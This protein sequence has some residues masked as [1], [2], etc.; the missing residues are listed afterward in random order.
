MR[1]AGQS[2]HTLEIAPYTY[3][4]TTCDAFKGRSAFVRLS[5]VLGAAFST[6]TTDR[7][8]VGN[9]LMRLREEDLKYFCDLFG[10]LTTVTGGEH[11]DKTPY[12][13]GLLFGTHFAGRYDA[14]FDWLCFC[15]D[16]NYSSFFENL[17]ALMTKYGRKSEESKP[18]SSEAPAS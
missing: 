2:K 14:M 5:N 4:V 12:L 17:P 7:A 13:K 16:A 3:E 1:Q 10:E 15:I 6:A 18:E 8:I 11:E 9:L